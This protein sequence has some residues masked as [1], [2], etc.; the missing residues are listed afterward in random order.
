[1]RIFSRFIPAAVATLAGA[2]AAPASAQTDAAPASSWALGAGVNVLQKGYRDIDRDV[3][4]LP[5]ISYE[6][7]WVSASVPTLD[8]KAYTGDTLSLRLRA[9]YT[10]DGYEA[11]DSPFLAGMSDRKGSFWVGGAFLWRPEYANFSAEVLRDAGG[12]SKATRARVQVDRRFAFGAFGL[13]P[14][15]GAEWV[16]D[17]FVDYYYGVRATEV[18][19]DRGFYQGDAS[20]NIDAG[21]SLD[22]SFS[23]R[24]SVFADVRMTRFGSA[25]KDSPLMEKSG[26]AGVSLGY[27]YRF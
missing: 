15:I 24:H 8:L 20:T 2:L 23:R 25:I 26:Q 17:K 14:R 1:M 13:T 19:A 27:V 11:K 10:R 22:Y 4:P 21:L 3:L 16:D 9:R 5:I 7:K 12:H 18:R 6:S